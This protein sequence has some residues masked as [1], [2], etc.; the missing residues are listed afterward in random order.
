MLPVTSSTT[1]CHDLNMCVWQCVTSWATWL[2][3]I[4]CGPKIGYVTQCSPYRSPLKNVSL[5]WDG[6]RWEEIWLIHNIIA[7]DKQRDVDLGTKEGCFPNL[8]IATDR[9]IDC[10]QIPTFMHNQ[11][12]MLP[13]IIVRTT[14]LEYA[15]ALY[16]V[17]IQFKSSQIYHIIMQF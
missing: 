8:F 14:S 12:E 5:G 2:N 13:L 16:Y 10:C 6:P 15:K 9:H 1:C 3:M 7:L 4:K 17:E 11:V